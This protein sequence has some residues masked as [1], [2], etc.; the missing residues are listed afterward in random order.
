M[1]RREKMPRFDRAKVR[2]HAHKLDGTGLRVW[3]DRA[4]G[5]LPDE[6]FPEL[7]ANYV[8]LEDVVADGRAEPDLLHSIRR[9]H[10]ESLAGRYYQDFMVSSRNFMEKSRGTETFIAEHSR[11]LDACMRAERAGDIDTAR[12]GLGLLIDLMRQIDRCEVNIVFFADEAGSWQVGVDW[13]EVLPA[14]FRSLSPATDPYDWAEAVVEAL[15]DF[16]GY[17]M[18]PLLAATR[19]IATPEQREALSEYDGNLRRRK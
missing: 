7:V 5:L 9:F 15:N 13:A 12:E 6:A 4:I 1:S 2:A 18:E 16:A 3:L 8:R 17:Q 14:W 10:R 19:S 11:L